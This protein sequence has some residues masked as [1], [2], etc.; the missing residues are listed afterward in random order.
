VSPTKAPRKLSTSDERRRVLVDAATRVFAAR[1]YHAAPTLE[2]AKAAG[3]SQAYLFRLFPSKVDLFVAVC[4][5]TRGRLVATFS[6]AAARAR[7]TGRDPLEEMGLAYGRIVDTEREVLLIQLHSQVAA[8]QEP[9]IRDAMCETFRQLYD[10]VRRES[11][12]G[13]E[14][15]RAWFAHGMLI[16][17]MTA[18]EADH[19]GDEWARALSDRAPEET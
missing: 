3:I 2:M 8:G 9:R 13:A 4:E 10:V 11:G 19:L 1:G 5:A 17:V 12:A 7:T 16:N 18:I 14:E 15:L 6:E